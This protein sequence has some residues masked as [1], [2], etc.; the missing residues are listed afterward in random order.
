MADCLFCKIRDGEIPAKLVYQ[1][2]RAFA[3]RDI[4]P[5][6]PTHILICPRQHIPTLNHLTDGET[7]LAGH[8]LVV[9]AKLAKDEGLADRGWR[10]LFNVNQDAGQL[11]FHI[12]LHLLGGRS[13][14]WPPG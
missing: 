6:A 11:V 2:D 8:L 4:Q 14:G 7:D 3:F 9:A 10:T 5:Q 1:D 13:F 12:H